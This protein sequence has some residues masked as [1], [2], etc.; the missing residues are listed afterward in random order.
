MEINYSSSCGCPKHPIAICIKCEL[1]DSLKMA[2]AFE[3]SGYVVFYQHCKKHQ[4]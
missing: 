2:N 1:F 3:K 4:D